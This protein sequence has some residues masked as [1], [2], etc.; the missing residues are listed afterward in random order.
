M[1]AALL[2]SSR[3]LTLNAGPETPRTPDDNYTDIPVPG[4]V[5]RTGPLARVMD[6]DITKAEA[7]WKSGEKLAAAGASNGMTIN[8][9][10]LMAAAAT[11]AAAG[12]AIAGLG[13]VAGAIIAVGVYVV[14]AIFGGNRPNE[15]EEAGAGPNV[16]WW[17]SNYGPEEY[18]QWVFSTNNTGVLV[19]VQHSAQGLLMYW[20]ATY[21]YVIHPGGVFYNGRG[22]MDYGYEAAGTQSADV[23]YAWV[24][25]FYANVGIDWDATVDLWAD[26]GRGP[27]LMKN[28]TFISDADGAPDDEQG[29]GTGSGS[30]ALV[31]GLGI[32]A[33][34]AILASQNR[35]R[36]TE[37]HTMARRKRKT[38]RR[39]SSTA[40]AAPRRKRARRM[41]AVKATRRRRIGASR[42]GVMAEVSI[43]GQM[44]VGALGAGL[45]S[46]LVDKVLPASVTTGPNAPYV[47][48]AVLVLGGVMLGKVMP[49]ARYVGY[50]VAT[51]GAVMIGG[52]LLAGTGL[53]NGNRRTLPPGALERIARDVRNGGQRYIGTGT[54]SST[55]TGNATP[56]RQHVIVGVHEDYFSE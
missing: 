20:L 7:W 17:F 10:E 38:T 21:N 29:A 55:L 33:L 14:G 41:G 45:V 34:V 27:L 18:K 51:M 25:Q 32:A 31:A 28:R 48:G 3:M 36:S 15:Y 46:G 6:F 22:D 52:K 8:P 11:G 30:G 42:S 56:R 23:A 44:A 43:V 50:G 4:G 35:S 39:R 12:A 54:K 2:N 49:K 26:E 40:V 13:A 24:R 1:R 53:L 5:V 37:P 19:D 16:N 9:S 47:K